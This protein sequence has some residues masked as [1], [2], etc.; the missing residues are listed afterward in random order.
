MD[1]KR[2]DELMRRIAEAIPPGARELR[3]DI[4]KNLRAFLSSALGSLNLVT[5]E[6]FDIQSAVLAR[7]R[8][9]LEQLEAQVAALEEQLL[10]KRSEHAVTPTGGPEPAAGGTGPGDAMGGE[11]GPEG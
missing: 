5:R 3:E 8:A 9:K 4:E 7:T 1:P 10:G 2:V 6:E 11:G